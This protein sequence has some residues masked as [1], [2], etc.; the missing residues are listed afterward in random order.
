MDWLHLESRAFWATFVAAF[1]AVALWET[2]CPERPLLVQTSR[3]W[4]VHGAILVLSTG[5]ATLFVRL[6]PVAAALSVEEYSWARPRWAW[7]IAA[8]LVLDLVKYLSH[9]LSHAVPLLWRLHRV[10]HADPD[11]DLTTSLR[12]HPLESL[13]V[14]GFNLGVILL[15]APPAAAVLAS[16]LF[17]CLANFFDHANAALPEMW[18]RKLRRW[19]VTPNLHRLH[20]TDDPAVQG[21][22]LGELLPWWDRL[23][24]TYREPGGLG[25]QYTIGL[26]G[27]QNPSSLNLAGM[28]MEPFFRQKRAP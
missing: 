5:L 27:Y 18:D 13:L 19:I 11:F 10:H 15:M 7:G 8:F 2:R 3:R 1:F 9:R 25:E 23:F 14:R 4:S 22:N 24:G 12:F 21:K 28:L 20:H 26:R 6:S 16:E 17:S